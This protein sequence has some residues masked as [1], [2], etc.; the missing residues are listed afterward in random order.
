V[1]NDAFEAWLLHRVA[2]AVEAGEVSAEL[3]T[4]LQAEIAE[5]RE[6]PPDARHAV[7]IQE[8]AERFDLTVNQFKA[9]LATVVT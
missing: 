3:L 7:A 1:G 4:D 2:Q 9:L 6:R 5:A 8:L